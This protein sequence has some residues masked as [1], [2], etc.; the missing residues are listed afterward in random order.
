LLAQ[1][2][3]VVKIVHS[4]LAIGDALEDLPENLRE[5]MGAAWRLK[6]HNL[7]VL[8]EQGQD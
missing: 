7:Q 4:P 5:S 6:L 3:E 1:F 2:I 8:E